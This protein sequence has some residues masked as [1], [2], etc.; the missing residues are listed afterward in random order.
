[1]WCY[2]KALHTW[3]NIKAAKKVRSC[4]IRH[5]ARKINRHGVV[6][7]LSS[8]ETEPPATRRS[9]KC[10]KKPPAS[11]NGNHNAA[12]CTDRKR[13]PI[14][15]PQILRRRLERA[16][17]NSLA[18]AARSMR[19]PHTAATQRWL[20]LATKTPLWGLRVVSRQMKTQ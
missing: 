2:V 19:C 10:R 8:V 13:C 12:E 16:G 20:G 4:L 1:V 5:Q 9:S 6:R 18:A 14:L 7:A 11:I 17:I 3:Y 15:Q